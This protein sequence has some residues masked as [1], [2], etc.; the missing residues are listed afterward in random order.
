[1]AQSGP[2]SR[3]SIQ[4]GIR[5]L[6]EAEEITRTD[7]WTK[8]QAD[9]MVKKATMTV[10]PELRHFRRNE[11][12]WEELVFHSRLQMKSSVRMNGMYLT[13]K[14]LLIETLYYKLYYYGY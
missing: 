1:M 13:Y 4:S 14:I 12:I 3:G 11:Q 10:P 8:S 5:G 2:G 9:E 6:R 7:L